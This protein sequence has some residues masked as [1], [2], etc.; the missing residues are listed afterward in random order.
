MTA[1]AFV[2]LVFTIV[3]AAGDWL[4]VHHRERRLEYLLKPLTILCLIGVA[5]AVDPQDPA[6]RA[7]FVGALVFSLAGDVFLM[8][9]RDGE[10]FVAGLGA[11]LVAH[12]AY[13]VGMLVEGVGG[14]G[15]LLGA[16][17]VAVLILVVGTQIVRAV[18]A[19]EP[20]LLAPVAVYMGVISAMVVAAIGVGRP[21][22]VVGAGLFYASDTMIG[23]TRFVRPHPRLPLAIIVTYHLGQ[24][25][26]VL[27]LI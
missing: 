19:S 25:G 15:L 12:L 1:V 20:V 14:Y 17:V 11:F 27:S 10:L 16:L 4:A 9:D 7:W 2:F 5:L 8:L 21:F 18:Q 13:V 23:W 26:L 22:G 3:V 6:A 24:I